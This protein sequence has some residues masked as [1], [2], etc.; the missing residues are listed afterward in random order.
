MQH[1]RVARHNGFAIA[2]KKDRTLPL[3]DP[4]PNNH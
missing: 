2:T 3:T 1:V 4:T